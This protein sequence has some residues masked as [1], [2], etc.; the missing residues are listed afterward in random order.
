[1]A[2]ADYPVR[3]IAAGFHFLEGP[4]WHDGHLYFSD[5]AD[6]KVYVLESDGR[7]EVVCQAPYWEARSSTACPRRSCR[8]S[9]WHWAVP[10]SK[11]STCARHRP[12]FPTIRAW[13]GGLSCSP[14]ELMCLEYQ[15]CDGLAVAGRRTGRRP[16]ANR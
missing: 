10:T 16:T 5:F 6:G 7:V 13:R 11:P 15:P 9:R 14:H 2:V 4:R 1:M 3:Q 12:C 8:S